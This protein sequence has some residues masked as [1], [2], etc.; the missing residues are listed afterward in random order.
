LELRECEI[1]LVYLIVM[2]FGIKHGSMM[3]DD[4][5]KSIQGDMGAYMKGHNPGFHEH[6]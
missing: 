4:H 6:A 1:E 3:L 2:I 5:F